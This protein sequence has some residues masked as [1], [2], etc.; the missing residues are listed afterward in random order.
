M[1]LSDAE[2]N[3]IALLVSKLEVRED[4]LRDPERM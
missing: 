4:S 2:W 3:T 1:H